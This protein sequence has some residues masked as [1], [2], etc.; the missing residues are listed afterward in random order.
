MKHSKL[1]L[2]GFG[3]DMILVLRWRSL[4]ELLP[5]NVPWALEFPG[6]PISW[7]QVSYLRD[8]TLTHYYRLCVPHP[9]STQQRRER[10]RLGWGG[11]EGKQTYK[12]TNIKEWTEK[13]LKINDESNTQQTRTPKEIHTFTNRRDKKEQKNKK[14]EPKKKSYQSNEMKMNN[15][16]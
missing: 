1:E 7:T 8:S 4:G 13:N 6:G 9:T 2:A 16:K 15:K 14:W 11:E 3:W 12:Q 10:K 5:I